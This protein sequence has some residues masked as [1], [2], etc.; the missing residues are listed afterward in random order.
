MSNRPAARLALRKGDRTK[1][2]RWVR[3][4][5]VPAG[6]ARRARIVLLA[7]DG[8]PN[9]DIAATVGVSRPTVN[10]WRDRYAEAGMSGLFDEQRPGRAKTVDQSKIITAMLAMVRKV[11]CGTRSYTNP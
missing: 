7:A 3:S 11:M 2:R 10:K 8:V 5:S 9:Q 1:L 4:S 6:R